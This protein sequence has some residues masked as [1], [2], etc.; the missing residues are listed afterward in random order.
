MEVAKKK[1]R[2]KTERAERVLA[3]PPVAEDEKPSRAVDGG[4]RRK[5][6]SPVAASESHPEA[7]SAI[8]RKARKPRKESVQMSESKRRKSPPP[9]TPPVFSS[10]LFS[11]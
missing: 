6:E 2:V 1:R 5:A 10:S 8:V 7:I 9:L 4:L 11:S 3:Q